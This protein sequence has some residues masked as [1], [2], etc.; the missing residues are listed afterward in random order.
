MLPDRMSMKRSD[1]VFTKAKYDYMRNGSSKDL[2]ETRMES[3]RLK[4]KR[5]KPPSAHRVVSRDERE[6][7]HKSEPS[8][9]KVV[10]I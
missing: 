2:M 6:T 7:V 8:K 10:F 5:E 4:V 9:K 3:W 1:V